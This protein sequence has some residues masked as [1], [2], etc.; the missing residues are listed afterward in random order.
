MIRQRKAR[1]WL[2]AGVMFLACPLAVILASACLIADPGAAV[3]ELPA[4]APR[5]LHGAV[6]PSNLG[7]LTGPFPIGF[8]IKVVI[9]DPSVRFE[10][11]LFIDYDPNDQTRN[12]GIAMADTSVPSPTN[13]GLTVRDLT[14]S[15]FNLIQYPADSCHI[16]EA[17]VADHFIGTAGAD[18]HTPVGE[19][20]SVV[21]LYNPSNDA[22]GC[23]VADAGPLPN[24]G[25]GDSSPFSGEGGD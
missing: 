16:I 13:A 25:G 15:N 21:W 22:V 24:F 20:D 23:P 5:I 10:Y 7:V 14:L 6:Y 9:P 17:I 11:R 3:P 1:T 19:S 12:Y 4:A 8:D 18:S 2:F